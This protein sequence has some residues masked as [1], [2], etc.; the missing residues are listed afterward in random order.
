MMLSAG[1]CL[2]VAQET[3]LDYSKLKGEAKA[4]AEKAKDKAKEAA[5]KADA[6]FGR[7]TRT[8]SEVL[9]DSK[10]TV[11][12]TA[13]WMRDKLK[14]NGD[15]N[16]I[17]KLTKDKLKNKFMQQI[18]DRYYP[19]IR[20]MERTV[21]LTQLDSAWKDHL[22]AMDHVRSS[23]NFRSMG[24]M[25]PK[26]EYKREGMRLFEQMWMSI[27]ER[28]TDVIFR[29]EAM[30]SDIVADS[31]IE[32]SATHESFDVTSELM[33]EKEADLAAAEQ[34]STE[35]ARVEPIRNRA[36]RAGRNDAC[37]CGSGK[38]YKNCCM[39]KQI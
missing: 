10:D 24:Q 16:D 19:E 12:S 38:K 5:A 2:L 22:L 14:W 4:T 39:R 34:V 37:P 28:M 9:A 21:L 30:D 25:D 26:V 3:A 35:P 17:K 15:A 23:V 6:L 1:L 13:Q 33:A 36:E 7:S 32:T 11:D 8:L 31:W 20:R 18:D 29:M 27:G